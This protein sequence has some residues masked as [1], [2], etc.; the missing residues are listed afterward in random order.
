V[1]KLLG[2]DIVVTGGT[3]A[4]T[5]SDLRSYVARFNLTWFLRRIGEI[6]CG[7]ERGQLDSIGG[8]HVSRHS[9]AYV[10]LV[11][12]AASSD[13]PELVPDFSNLAEA[14]RIFNCLH[15]PLV[16][17]AESSD[18]AL[19]H[20]IRVGYS[21]LS[22]GA[23]LQNLIARTSIIFGAAWA[24]SPDASRFDVA[25]AIEATTGVTQA[26]L[27]VLGLAFSG[28]ALTVGSAGYVT[29][30]DKQVLAK[31][32]PGLGIGSEQQARFLNWVSATYAEIRELA[33]RVQV[34]NETYEKYRLSPLLLTPLVRPDRP[35]PT[36]TKDVYLAPVPA[37]LARRVTD[38]IY[39]ALATANQGSG[40][41][42][43]FR[44]AFGFAFQEYVGELLNVGSPSGTVLREWEYGKRHGRRQTPDWLVHEEDRLLVIEVKQSVVTLNTKMLGHMA[45]LAENLEKTLTAAVRQLLTFKSDL[46][47]GAPDLERL[48]GVRHVELLVVTH[49]EVPFGNWVMRNVI[50]DREPGADTVQICSIDEFEEM[51]RYCWGRSPFDLLSAKR[52]GP[53]NASEFGLSQWLQAR[54]SAPFPKHPLLHQAFEQLMTTLGVTGANG[55]D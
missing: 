22:G 31:F 52:L 2:F 47:A 19:E 43:A 7:L 13:E 6:T 11:A 20:L 48:H 53:G 9:L 5:V 33:A 55:E 41:A 30:Y 51:Q 32:P 27:L 14:V 49:D 25:A 16:E 44:A 36:A 23:D 35:P 38:G 45:S 10:A 37:Y 46:E 24:R 29:P 26:Q 50:A 8:V 12:I 54:G 21:Q 18:A 15:D 17:E 4:T 3:E 39:H 34:P 40:K 28:R 42:N 1:G